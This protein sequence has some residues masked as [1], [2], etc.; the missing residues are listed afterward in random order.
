MTSETE[1]GKSGSF[2]QIFTRGYWKNKKKEKKDKKLAADKSEMRKFVLSYRDTVNEAYDHALFAHAGNPPQQI[3]E[4]KKTLDADF[5]SLLKRIDNMQTNDDYE[6]VDDR[7]VELLNNRAFLYPENE[8][9]AE[10]RAK[11][12]EILSWGV[13]PEQREPIEHSISMI[14]DCKSAEGEKRAHLLKVYESYDELDDYVDW[15]NKKLLVTGILLLSAAIGGLALSLIFLALIRWIIPGMVMAGASGAALSI[16]LRLPPHPQYGAI[17][18]F[19]VKALSR[20]ATGILATV[21]GY[22]FLAANIIT[23]NVNLGENAKSVNDLLNN[24]DWNKATVW[25]IFLIISI[26]IILGSTER[27]FSR[28]A[29]SLLPEKKSAA[30]KR[31][32]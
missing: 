9:E 11:Y 29:G 3:R 22:S 5:E 23:F 2:W 26:G 20:F 21:V 32:D 1:S 30:K 17:R 15:I 31:E 24:W 13:S 25:N 7:G 16:L 18:T 4:Y 6:Y 27:L 19:G 14:K 8:L 10:A 12:E 28:L